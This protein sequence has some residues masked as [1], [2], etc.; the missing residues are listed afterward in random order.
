MD[1]LTYY[2]SPP[3]RVVLGHLNHNG[4]SPIS[5]MANL[6]LLTKVATSHI[7]MEENSS[8]QEAEA[9]KTIS[10][11]EIKCNRRLRSLSF[12]CQK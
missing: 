3:K 10:N 11:D 1:P 6:K 7:S 4:N 12:I 2:K 5:P 9:L 8:F